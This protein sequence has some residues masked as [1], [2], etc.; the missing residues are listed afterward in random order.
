M[1]NTE[2]AQKGGEWDKRGE[3]KKHESELKGSQR[4]IQDATKIHSSPPQVRQDL[5]QEHLQT[6]LTGNETLSS[7]DIFQ[8]QGCENLSKTSAAIREAYTLLLLFL[9]YHTQDTYWGVKSTMVQKQIPFIDRYFC[10]LLEKYLPLTSEDKPTSCPPSGKETFLPQGTSS[11]SDLK[12]K[13]G[14]RKALEK[15]LFPGKY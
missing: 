6:F 8:K 2:N 14:K 10:L 12:K 1:K 3:K 7:A 4:Q 9:G 15:T 5:R 13:N 11:N